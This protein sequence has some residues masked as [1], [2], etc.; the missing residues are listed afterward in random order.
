VPDGA[1]GAIITW[2]EY[3][4]NNSAIYAQRVDSSGKVLWT[5]GGVPIR[6]ISGSSAYDPRI[7][8]DGAGGAI[9]AWYDYRSG[10]KIYAQAQVEQLFLTDPLK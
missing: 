7:A 2:Y 9:I 10:V 3:R 4:G 1:G 8:S 6:S 5:T